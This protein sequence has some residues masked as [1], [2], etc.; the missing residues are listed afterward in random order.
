MNH[1]ITKQSGD[2]S[3]VYAPYYKTCTNGDARPI[4]PL[5]EFYLDDD[6]KLRIKFRYHLFVYPDGDTLQ[7]KFSDWAADPTKPVSGPYCWNGDPNK[8]YTFDFNFDSGNPSDL[9]NFNAGC[10]DGIPDD[11]CVPPNLMGCEGGAEADIHSTQSATLDLS[12]TFYLA[13]GCALL[14]ACTVCLGCWVRRLKRDVRGYRVELE[15]R[16]SMVDHVSGGGEDGRGEEY[17]K[18]KGGEE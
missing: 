9:V 15:G 7:S 2:I 4:L 1:T 16:R 14:A 3:D 17:Q 13:V 5:I 18:L 10:V 8:G 6:E 12:L 11:A